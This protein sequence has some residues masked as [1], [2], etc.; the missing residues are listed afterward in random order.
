MFNSDQPQ[1]VFWGEMSPCEHFVEIYEHDGPFL[2]SLEGFAA[3]GLKAHDAVIIIATSEHRMALEKR[4]SKRGINVDQMRA[5]QRY[6]DID[7]EAA[8]SQFMQNDWPND[9]LFSNFI[10]NLL[11]RATTGGRQ[12]R[13]FGEMVALLWLRGQ[14]GATVRLEHLW[15]EVCQAE[16]LTL[17]C[18]YPKIGFTKDADTS[19]KE[20]CALHS[21]A[22]VA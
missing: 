20:I 2:D 7:A 10:M 5:S 22:F 3:G 19:I 12:V 14:N 18:A 4:L 8:L 1:A 17:F 15:H 13:A 6:I 9:Q 11:R 16:G 21:Q